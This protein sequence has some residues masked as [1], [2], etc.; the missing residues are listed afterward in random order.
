MTIIA[1]TAAILAVL[2]AASGAAQAGPKFNTEIGQVR[3]NVSVQQGVAIA[4]DDS[5]AEVGAASICNAKIGRAEQNVHVKQG[6]AIAVGGS[7]A[8][9][10]AA[11]IGGGC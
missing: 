7:T 9:V 11:Q 1:K 5:T 8:R 4:V 6:V 2:A 10:G 3:Q